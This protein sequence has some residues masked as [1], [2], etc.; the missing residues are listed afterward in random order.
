MQHGSAMSRGQSS[1]GRGSLYYTSN[2]QPAPP[3]VSQQQLL[4]QA[5]ASGRPSSTVG[6]P[7]AFPSSASQPQQLTVANPASA[8]FYTPGL[9]PSDVHSHASTGQPPHPSTHPPLGNQQELTGVSVEQLNSLV[10]TMVAER[11]HS[12]LATPRQAGLQPSALQMASSQ[13]GGRRSQSVVENTSHFG[14]TQQT[15]FSVAGQDTPGSQMQRGPR[16]SPSGVSE[17]SQAAQQFVHQPSATFASLGA[18]RGGL[19]VSQRSSRLQ[20]SPTS[21]QPWGSRVA[22]QRDPSFEASPWSRGPLSKPAAQLSPTSVVAD[23]SQ[24][25]PHHQYPSRASYQ[26]SFP[27]TTQQDHPLHPV[28]PPLNLTQHLH[29]LAQQSRQASHLSPTSQSRAHAHVSQQ[30]QSLAQQQQQS[31]GAPAPFSGS[32]PQPGNPSQ[33]FS[34]PAGPASSSPR[35][36]ALADSAGLTGVLDSLL[37]QGAAA[38]LPVDCT[39]LFNVIV[40]LLE[41]VSRQDTVVQQLYAGYDDLSEQFRDLAATVQPPLADDALQQMLGTV[42]ERVH[43][44][45]GLCEEVAG[46]VADNLRGLKSE[47][48]GQKEALTETAEAVADDIQKL[49]QRVEGLEAAVVALESPVASDRAALQHA[50]QDLANLRD[51]VDKLAQPGSPAVASSVR[52]DLRELAEARAALTDQH[53]DLANRLQQYDAAHKQLYA[54][55]DLPSD[56]SPHL[57]TNDKRIQFLRDRAWLRP[58]L[59]DITNLSSRVDTSLQQQ[60]KAMQEHPFARQGQYSPQSPEQYGVGQHSPRVSP[61]RQYAPRLPVTPPSSWFHSLFTESFIPFSL[62]PTKT[63]VPLRT[64]FPSG[65]FSAQRHKRTVRRRYCVAPRSIIGFAAVALLLLLR[66]QRSLARPL[67]ASSL[68]FFPSFFLL[69]N[70]ACHPYSVLFGGHGI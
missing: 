45:E 49:A 59:Q 58:A 62:H 10:E 6:E 47:V 63:P 50:Q 19:N 29:S 51:V 57:D 14:H 43:A 39:L 69:G 34:Q 42:T 65:I 56:L 38:L 3:P 11:L 21:G 68:R 54:L 23:Q 15:P 9:R 32:Q 41:A 44:V 31:A 30:L 1:A 27:S 18:S 8:A 36:L 70:T 46:E 26:P 24:Q 66:F 20:A 48:A 17:Q 4:Q 7:Q 13:G 35:Q 37:Q 33:A 67:S 52:N 16:N 61:Y 64:L 28:V 55:F 40:A 53:N 60:Q 25:Q 5:S 22:S 12:H 2:E